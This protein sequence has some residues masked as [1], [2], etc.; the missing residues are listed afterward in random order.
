MIQN[1]R[2]NLLLYEDI[3][4]D[5]PVLGFSPVIEPTPTLDGPRN[6]SSQPGDN[7]LSDP[8]IPLISDFVHSAT[9]AGLNRLSLDGLELLGPISE[10]GTFMVTRHSSLIPGLDLVAVKRTKFAIPQGA[11][12]DHTLTRRMKSISHEIAILMHPNLRT[13]KYILRLF[14]WDW[15]ED[16][17]NE[18]TNRGVSPALI[19]E[20]AAVGPLNRYLLSRPATSTEKILWCAQV[21]SALRSVHRCGIVHGDVKP[22]NVLLCQDGSGDINAK[23][24]DFGNALFTESEEGTYTCTALYAAPEIK[25][26][27]YVERD[28]LKLCDIFSFGLLIWEVL[29]DGMNY[30]VPNS[31]ENSLDEF[32]DMDTS[33]VI[34]QMSLDIEDAESQDS[35]VQIRTGSAL[36]NEAL[37]ACEALTNQSHRTQFKLALL[38]TL[39]ENPRL[40]IQALDEVEAGLWKGL[41]R[42]Q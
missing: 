21:C 28:H 11:T 26:G 13:H 27:T 40:R 9:Q 18:Y 30:P 35:E 1:L 23:L 38:K 12:Y 16:W 4:M 3:T 37:K 14:G 2:V 20:Y 22:E 17:Q 39:Q 24:S 42:A 8:S 6:A 25:A 31:T 29:I 7:S 19:M 36:L 34:E 33:S 15:F 10:G 41:S 32:E 5:S